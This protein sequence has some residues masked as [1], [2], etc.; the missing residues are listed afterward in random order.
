MT[1]KPKPASMDRGEIVSH[2]DRWKSKLSS[3]ISEL[4]TTEWEYV[5]CVHTLISVFVDVLTPDTTAAAKAAAAQR[6]EVV[7]GKNGYIRPKKSKKKK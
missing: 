5:S 2:V 1:D 7:R 4:F 3:S 6:T